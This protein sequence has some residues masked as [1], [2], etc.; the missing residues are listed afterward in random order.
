MGAGWGE[1]WGR[2]GVSSGGRMVAEGG[3]YLPLGHRQQCCVFSKRKKQ[4]QSTG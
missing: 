1:Q 4:T 2:G 3:L